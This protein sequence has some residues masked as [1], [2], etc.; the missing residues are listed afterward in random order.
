M[1]SPMEMG[2]YRSSDSRVS[3]AWRAEA[4]GVG[5]SSSSEER[6]EPLGGYGSRKP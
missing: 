6:S 2:A 4:G 3:G 1:V 5:F